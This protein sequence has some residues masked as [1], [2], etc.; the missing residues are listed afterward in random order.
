MGVTPETC[1][2][3]L[4]SSVDSLQWNVPRQIPMILPR[5]LMHHEGLMM[6]LVLLSTLLACV[7]RSPPPSTTDVT[8]PS[9]RD[10]GAA[11]V[12]DESSEDVPSEL[13]DEYCEMLEECANWMQT[14]GALQLTANPSCAALGKS[15]IEV[16]D[17]A[18]MCRSRGP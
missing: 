9:P 10:T 13:D 6:S 8:L 3:L 11:E 15:A 2:G 1:S 5:C 7:E 17:A 4:G 18:K 12:S 16:P 14:R